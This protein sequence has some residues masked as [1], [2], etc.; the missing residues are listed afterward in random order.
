MTSQLPI[1]TRVITPG[2]LGTTIE[3][4][5]ATAPTFE[6]VKL[7]RSLTVLRYPRSQIRVAS[8]DET[9]LDPESE[10]GAAPI[11]VAVALIIAL[12]LVAIVFTWGYK[13]GQASNDE[14]QQPDCTLV[15]RGADSDNANFDWFV[16]S[17]YK[18]DYRPTG[19]G[20]GNWYLQPEPDTGWAYFGSALAEDA[21]IWSSPDCLAGR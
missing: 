7:D 13:F 4:N 19:D 5:F 14:T 16:E 18:V 3:P 8:P 6:R 10:T 1:G 17:V 2:G 15:A 20:Y 9:G 11:E 12:V 21:D